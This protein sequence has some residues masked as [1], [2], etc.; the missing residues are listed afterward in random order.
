MKIIK[1]GGR[2]LASDHG[3]DNAIRI[4]RNQSKNEK[5][6]VVVSAIGDTTDTL[7]KIF[8]K[9]KKQN[10]YV[11]AFEEFKSRP[12]HLETDLTEEFGLLQK[13]FEGVSLIADYSPKIRDLVLA[14]GELISIKVLSEQFS[15]RNINAIPVDSRK[16][17]LA[18][19]NYGNAVADEQKSALKTKELFSKFDK[20]SIPVVSG[21]IASTQKGDTVTLGRSGSNYSAALLAKFVKAKELRNYTHVDG[22]FTANPDWVRNSRKIDRLSYEDANEL[23]NFGASILHSKTIQP[24][25][26]N[27]IPIRIL[28]T[29]KPDEKGTLI[30]EKPTQEGIRSLSLQSEVA[31]IRLNGQGLLG[32][33]GID[34]RI[35]GVLAKENVSVGLIAQGTSERG[36]GFIVSEKDAEKAA[37]ALQNEF[38]KDFDSGDVDRISI[39]KDI[40]VISIVG[41]DLSSFDKAYSALVKNKI[42]PI[43]FSNAVTGKNVSLVVEK[44]QSKKALNVIHGQIFGISKTVNLVLFGHGNVG[45]ALIGQ[46]LESVEKIEKKKNIRLNIFGI[47]NSKKILLDENGIGKDWKSRIEIEGGNYTIEDIIRFSDEHH[48]ENLIAVDNTAS[49][50][51]TK[52]YIRLIENGFDL[53]SSNKIA[54]TVDY[55][56]YKKL[57]ESLKLNH[58]EY[59]YETNVGA[60][61]PLIDTIKLLHLSGE[62]ITRIRGVFSG[63]L[64]YIFNR[65]SKDEAALSEILDDA[66]ELGFTEPDPREDLSGNDVGRKLLVLARE[67]DLK[68]EWDEIRIQN[69]IP[70]ELQ[71]ISTKEFLEKKEGLDYYFGLVKKNL[72]AGMVL[73]YVGELSGDLQ[74]EKGLLETRLVEV[75][76]DSALGQLKGSDSIFEIYTESYGEHPIVI[77]GAGAGAGVTAR[78]VFGD[79]LRLADR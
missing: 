33:S 30:S 22:I 1:F 79:I 24:L 34:G 78:G 26:E 41:Q 31:L 64:S 38:K 10:G 69:L 47:A 18:D 55:E 45:N 51:F 49:K 72:E 16:I 32:K 12:Y 71:Q 52:N 23:A 39:R 3:F 43:L 2:S 59:L 75:P 17:F 46:I 5:I 73:R 42:I 7:E 48:L 28:N 19:E 27:K 44:E 50:A 35:F 37:N 66:I 25:V 36:I 60:G 58:K 8:E 76:S 70:K 63:S 61:L 65:F 53:I 68:N 9:A 4:V 77:Q 40:A 11:A 67:L 14:Q 15:K 54:N 20:N 6:A 62:N 56:F 13:L 57:R 29:L 74:Q 21:F